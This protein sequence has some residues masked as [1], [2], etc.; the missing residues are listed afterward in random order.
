MPVNNNQTGQSAATRLASLP[1]VRSACAKLSVL[2][3]V[4]KCS[5]PI[6]KSACD[7]LES[8][9]TALGA[10]A[11]NRVSPVIAKL[12]PQISIAND[13]ACKSLDWLE[14]SFPILLSP[15]E[16]IVATAKNKMHEIQ[17]VVSITANGTK[18][19]VQHTV[20][21]VVSRMHQA[22]DGADGSLV[23]R[24]IGATSEGLDSVLSLSEA[25]MDQLL[26]PTEDE[27]E[28][29][30]LVEGFEAATLRGRC[31]AQ[32]VSLTTRLYRRSCH[33]VGSRFQC[34]QVTE[35]LS[36]SSALVQDL[37][38]SLVTIVWILQGLP[39]YLQHQ[40]VSVSFFISQMY[41]TCPPFQQKQSNKARN[42]VSTAED[43]SL[44]RHVDQVHQ[45]LGPTCRMRPTKRSIFENGCNIKGCMRR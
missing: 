13:V 28:E 18:E 15:T 9:V 40:A 31:S 12:E 1:V 37:Q 27:T 41:I 38:A 45:Q 33:V 43:S 42:S 44:Q 4:T 22:G 20:T 11:R 16:Q 21:W 7:M 26:P 19:V 3:A 24:A 23:K 39:Q 17:D 29:A 36:R 6:L 30:H 5:H 10:A 2:Y 8:S 35:T 14:T 34:I 32:L 25:L